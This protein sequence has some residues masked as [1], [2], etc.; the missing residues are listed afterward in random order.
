MQPTP[1]ANAQ[2][3]SL[4]ERDPLTNLNHQLPLSPSVSRD[5]FVQECSDLIEGVDPRRHTFPEVRSIRLP[6]TRLSVT[7]FQLYEAWKML[8]QRESTGLRGGLQASAAGVGKTFIVISMLVLRSRAYEISREVREFWSKPTVTGSS[9]G[10]KPASAKHLPIT[11]RGSGHKCPSQA[12]GDLICYCV[13]TSKAREF[14]DA[15]VAPR[16]AALVQAPFGV[17]PQWI[18][19]FESANLDASAYNL[20]ISHPATPARLKR[21]FASVTKTLDQPGVKG[22]NHA[23]ETYIFVSSHTNERVISAFTE[24]GVPLG[25]HFSDES[26]GAMRVETGPMAISQ[27]QANIGDGLDLWLVSATPIRLLADFELPIG[28]ISGSN[29]LGRCAAMANLVKAHATARSSTRD[30]ES[31]LAHWSRVFDNRLVRRNTV[32]AQFTGRPITGLRVT[33]PESKWL[34]TPQQHIH[35]VQEIA[36]STRGVIRQKARDAEQNGEKFTPDYT[37]NIYARLHFVSLFPGAAGLV[38]SG[39]LKVEQ[40]EVENLIRKIKVSDKLKVENIESFTRHVEEAARGSPKLEFILAEIGRMRA[41]REQREEDPSL[42]KTLHAENLSLKKMVIITPNL[43]TAVMLTIFLQKRIPNL[44]PVCFHALSSPEHRE[45]ALNSFESL[46]ARKNAKHSYVL[47][48]PFAVGGTGL[49]LQSA[50]YQIFT[51]PPSSRDM[52]TQGF[53]RTNRIGQRLTLHHSVLIMQDNPADKICIV[54]FAARTILGDPFEDIKRDLVLA[55]P[56]GTKRIQ[57]LSDWGY[58]VHNHE[59][60]YKAVEMVYSTAIPQDQCHAREIT[61]PGYH[62]VDNMD[63]FDYFDAGSVAGDTLAVSEAWNEFDPRPRHEILRLRDIYLAFWVHELDRPPQGLRRF[64]YFTIKE[65]VLRNTLW[66]WIYALMG[67]QITEILIIRR[68]ARSAGEQRAFDALLERAPFCIG[69]QKMLDEYSEFAGVSIVA[70]EFLPE[71]PSSAS[72]L[73]TFHFRITLA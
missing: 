43:A 71:P 37:L 47:V 22:S 1:S 40:A 62:A 13:P 56:D 36:H 45:A 26:H 2:L 55:A 50:N 6:K 70:F 46:T 53:A 4:L 60:Y 10:A 65:E 23:P 59:V 29:D 52:Q 38:V 12:K 33:K 49:N 8:N 17:I 63:V 27:A 39:E 64:L 67:E 20:V 54:N 11:T 24:G 30:M 31:F 58:R 35:A 66:P 48:T 68:D 44:N 5:E 41:D 15:G 9:R 42:Q 73:I 21:D 19:V 3:A 25:V 7:P 72:R 28:I 34:E 69:V 32:S 16:G 61:H 51:F 57:R 14:V 18:A